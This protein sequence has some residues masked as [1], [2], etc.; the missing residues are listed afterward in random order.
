[1]NSFILDDVYLLCDMIINI[2][3]HSAFQS[4]ATK[5]TIENIGLK[6]DPNQLEFDFMKDQMEFEFLKHV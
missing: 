5:L 1:M 4:S 3:D 2:L 6:T